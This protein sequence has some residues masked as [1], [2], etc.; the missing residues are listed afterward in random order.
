MILTYKGLKKEMLGFKDFKPKTIILREYFLNPRYIVKCLE[1][2]Y[3]NWS[4]LGLKM[5]TLLL[6]LK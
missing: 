4:L 6:I 5:C 1:E 3:Y 2:D